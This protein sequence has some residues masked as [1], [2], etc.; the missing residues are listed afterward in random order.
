MGS[1]VLVVGAGV[2]GCAIARDLASDHDVRVLERDAVGSGATDRGAGEVTV[3][4]TYTDYPAVGDHA[5]DFFRTYDGTGDFW[6]VESGSVELV[7]PD[8]EGEARRR[9]ERLAD[10]GF[11]TAFLEPETVESRYPRF[12]VSNYVGAVYHGE[13]GFTD[14][15]T[16]VR[17]LADDATQRGATIETGVEVT[18]LDVADG[19]VRGVETSD[20]TIAADHVVVA[21]G[22]RTTDLL[23]DILELPVRPYRTQCAVFSPDQPLSDDFPLG[24]VP[25]E[26]VYF[27]RKRDGDL[28]V[29]GFSFAENEPATASRDSDEAFRTHALERLSAFLDPF[30]DPTLVDHWAGVDAATPDTRPIIDAPG[31]APDGLVVATGFHGRGIMTAPAAATA[32]R[33]LVTREETDVPLEPFRLDRLD[34]RARDFEFTSI[35]DGGE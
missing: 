18:G 20:G 21:A 1:D 4:P 13:T 10:E 12:D 8:R 6:Y 29:G 11:D 24:W 34:S 19:E 27:R 25:G 3:T 31:D 33:A 7:P 2:V 9:A 30:D 5:N 15:P 28:L 16:L 35:S 32:V 17:A 14:P 22:W 23:A 26:H